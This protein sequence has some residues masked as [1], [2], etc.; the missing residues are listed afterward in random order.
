[1]CIKQRRRFVNLLE[2]R[3]RVY[4]KVHLLLNSEQ[5]Y[6]VVNIVAKQVVIIIIRYDNS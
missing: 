5:N 3:K 6:S 1:M 4:V 2:K